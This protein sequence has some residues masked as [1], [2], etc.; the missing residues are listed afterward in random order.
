MWKEN[1]KKQ[2]KEESKL[3]VIKK[4]GEN[5]QEEKRNQT[6]ERE[7]EK[8][9]RK[10]SYK[11]I[12]ESEQYYNDNYSEIIKNGKIETVKRKSPRKIF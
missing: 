10:E 8:N 9:L 2:E 11:R 1:A 5:C 6:Q 7:R 3:N 12:S 4:N